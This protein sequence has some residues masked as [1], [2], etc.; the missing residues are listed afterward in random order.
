MCA[1]REQLFAV[2]KL[3]VSL[4]WSLI[5]NSLLTSSPEAVTVSFS[6]KSVFKASLIYRRTFKIN[7]I[8]RQTIQMLR[9]KHGSRSFILKIIPIHKAWFKF[10]FSTRLIRWCSVSPFQTILQTLF[11]DQSDKFIHFGNSWFERNLNYANLCTVSCSCRGEREE[12]S[13]RFII[14]CF[15]FNLIFTVAR[16]RRSWENFRSKCVN[17]NEIECAWNGKSIRNAEAEAH[18][19]KSI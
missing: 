12:D 10:R 7:L 13:N 17:W 1:G 18:S 5:H 9:T 3:H 8:Y 19:K 15:T 14:R 6:S 4:L 2:G 11:S 16:R